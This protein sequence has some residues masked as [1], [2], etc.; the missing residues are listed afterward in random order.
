MSICDLCQLSSPSGCTKLSNEVCLKDAFKL[1][2]ATA[3][4]GD[5]IRLIFPFAKARWITQ[6]RIGITV[7]ENQDYITEF[8]LKWW[9][10]PY[11]VGDTDGNS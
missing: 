10:A 4:N 8:D 9:N 2:R 1:I 3:T 7:S 5:V 11:K 6:S